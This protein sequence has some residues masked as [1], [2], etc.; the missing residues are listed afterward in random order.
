MV[1]ELEELPHIE[2]KDIAKVLHKVM[3]HVNISGS[4]K[5]DVLFKVSYTYI[6]YNI[7]N[8]RFSNEQILKTIGLSRHIFDHYIK[9]HEILVIKSEFYKENLIDNS[10]VALKKINEHRKEKINKLK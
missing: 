9:R 10:Y 3:P 8:G 5:P 2:F 7:F 1:R 4:K 6:C